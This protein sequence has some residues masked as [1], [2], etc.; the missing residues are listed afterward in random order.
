MVKLRE[1]SYEEASKSVRQIITEADIPD[2][3]SVTF[4][5]KFS[6]T[7]FI[8]QVATKTQISR[9]IRQKREQIQ[10][11]IIMIRTSM[12]KFDRDFLNL[13]DLSLIINARANLLSDCL[14]IHVSDICNKSHIMSSTIYPP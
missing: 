3:P 7:K 4:K 11:P 10:W 14:N 2:N 6:T 13:N 8:E 5:R 9:G 12:F 1:A